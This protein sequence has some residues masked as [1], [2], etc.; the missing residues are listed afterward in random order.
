[1]FAVRTAQARDATRALKDLLAKTI[2]FLVDERTGYSAPVLSEL[3]ELVDGLQ[4]A[5]SA[6]EVDAAATRLRSFHGGTTAETA[7][8]PVAIA[9]QDPDRN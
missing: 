9:A 7:V 2:A 4:R 1:M 8:L 3:G 6:T 5:L